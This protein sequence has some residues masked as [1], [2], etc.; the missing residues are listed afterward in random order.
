MT[1]VLEE[2]VDLASVAVAGTVFVHEVGKRISWKAH[3]NQPRHYAP[4][5][6]LSGVIITRF[7]NGKLGF[8]YRIRLDMVWDEAGHWCPGQ[9]MVV[10]NIPSSSIFPL[11][12]D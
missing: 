11:F 10:G 8:T 7:L 3:V 9:H 5:E 12:Q 4:D 1:H 2:E 6:L